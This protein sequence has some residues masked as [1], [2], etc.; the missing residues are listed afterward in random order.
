M[1]NWLRLLKTGFLVRKNELLLALIVLLYLILFRFILSIPL[2]EEHIFIFQVFFLFMENYITICAYNGLKESLLKGTL[3]I[4]QLFKNSILFFG[5]MLLYKMFVGL[6]AIIIMSFGFGMIEVVK[7]ASLV[8]STLVMLITIVW[9]SFP[10]Y[11]VLLTFLTPFVI[12]VDD[13]P[14]LSAMKKSV[15]VL[16]KNLTT[17]IIL[18]FSVLPLWVFAFFL[19]KL[20]N[21]KGLLFQLF[22]LCL[23]AILEII[24]IKIWMLFYQKTST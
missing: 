18:I 20:Y 9:L 16:R 24:T 4:G 14:V 10:V 15:K 1:A 2:R 11:L 3:N 19:L 13:V 23:I 7:N 12:V 17:S 8:K 5:R 21:E 22:L 6:V